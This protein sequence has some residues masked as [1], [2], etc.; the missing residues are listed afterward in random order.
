[1]DSLGVQELRAMY[2]GVIALQYDFKEVMYPENE[3][4]ERRA[5]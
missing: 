5:A 2:F 1:M 4:Q 3:A